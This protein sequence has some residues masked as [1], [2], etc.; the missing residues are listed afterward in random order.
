[1]SIRDDVGGLG[2]VRRGLVADLSRKLEGEVPRLDPYVCPR[3][4]DSAAGATIIPSLRASPIQ[5]V[6]EHRGVQVQDVVVSGLGAS[7]LD[8]LSTVQYPASPL[9]FSA[10]VAPRSRS[11]SLRLREGSPVVRATTLTSHALPRTSS[12]GASKRRMEDFLAYV[13]ALDAERLSNTSHESRS[14]S[15]SGVKRHSNEKSTR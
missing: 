6:S 15:L 10:R 3:H 4:R 1:M 13:V 2:G 14:D 9:H 7:V 11:N 8:T 5:K 12:N